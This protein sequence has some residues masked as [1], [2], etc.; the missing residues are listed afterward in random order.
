MAEHLPDGPTPLLRRRRREGVVGGGQPSDEGGHPAAAFGVAV[1]DRA[2]ERFDGGSGGVGGGERTF[3]V[4]DVLV[5]VAM[6]VYQKGAGAAFERVQDR[7]RGARDHRVQ[8]RRRIECERRDVLGVDAA[9]VRVQGLVGDVF[10]VDHGVVVGR[11]GAGQHLRPAHFLPA[12]PET[13]VSE[14]RSHGPAFAEIDRQLGRRQ[15]RDET[16]EPLARLI[17]GLLEAPVRHG[18]SSISGFLAPRDR[19]DALSPRSG[20]GTWHRTRR[21]GLRQCYRGFGRAAPQATP[22]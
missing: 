22:R 19:A 12:I 6:P 8:L 14:G 10:G 17:V 1:D 7:V 16:C 5:A 18:V 21:R 3:D 20:S 11:P 13:H 2:I 4:V 15:R 9:P